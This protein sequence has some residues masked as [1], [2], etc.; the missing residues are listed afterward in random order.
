MKKLIILVIFCIASYRVSA[1]YSAVRI[2]TLALA[3]GCLNVGVDTAVGKKT[4][5]DISAIW[6]PLLNHSTAFSG[7][8]RFWRFEPNV[9]WFLAANSTTSNFKIDNKKGWTTGLG[10]SLGYSWILSR[11]CNFT[12]EGGLGVYFLKDRWLVAD[13]SPLDDIIIRH[14]ERFMLLPSKLEASFSYLF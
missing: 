1:Q 13:T 11:R 2:N 7:G 4:S 9:G 10:C 8:V 6:S 14:R 12:L 3:V 5:I